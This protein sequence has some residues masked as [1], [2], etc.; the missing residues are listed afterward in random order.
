L[1]FLLL[2]KILERIATFFGDGFGSFFRPTR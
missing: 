2:K 1:L